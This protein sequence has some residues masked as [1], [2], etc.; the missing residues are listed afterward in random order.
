MT[1][2]WEEMGLEEGGM[3]GKNSTRHTTR[4]SQKDT[5]KEQNDEKPISHKC[6]SAVTNN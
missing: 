1:R 5:S 4:S 3:T 2:K 6:S